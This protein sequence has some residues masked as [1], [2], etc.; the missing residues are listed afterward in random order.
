MNQ[1]LRVAIVDYQ[2]GNIFSVINACKHVGLEPI[3]TSHKDDII[4][5]D[6]VILPGVGAFNDAMKRLNNLKLVN[7]LIDQIEQGKPFFCICLGMQLLFSESDEFGKS[8]GLDI[9]KGK[10]VKFKK[11]DNI[12]IPQ[13]CWNTIYLN[14]EN[15]SWSN[16][17]L[18]TISI[19]EYFYFVHSYYVLPKN[20]NLILSYTD[21]E[22]IEYCS[23][24]QYKN[25][26]ACQFHP[27]KSGLKGL[28][29]YNNFKKIIIKGY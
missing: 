9:V 16:T 26:F 7:I 27:E 6:A 5:S 23:S 19:Y 15:S 21:Y 3:L 13:I 12:K 18:E 8:K 22:E 14:T 24:I 20:K 11:N 1:R 25:L 17:P 2:L 10:V 4:N 29:I 28:E